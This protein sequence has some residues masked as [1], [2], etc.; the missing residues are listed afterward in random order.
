MIAPVISVVPQNPDSKRCLNKQLK[1]V[2]I[3]CRAEIRYSDCPTDRF[4]QA[5]QRSRCPS[6]RSFL[7]FPSPRCLSA[8]TAAPCQT[9][10]V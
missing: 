7:V 5:L 6:C 10:I 4:R 1:R 3:T 9:Q 2:I 8:S